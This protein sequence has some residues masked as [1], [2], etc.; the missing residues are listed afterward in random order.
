ML[1]VCAYQLKGVL[2]KLFQL[3]L[4]TCTVPKSWKLS[5]IVPVPKKPVA[6][7]LN[8]F[9]HI[10]LT[11]IL[12]KSM[13]RVVSKHITSSVSCSLDYLQFAYKSNR[14]TDDATVTLFNIIAKHLQVTNHYARVLFIDFTS[15]FNT[16]QIHIL[17][18][19]LVDL[20][21]NGG[22]IH[23]VRDFLSNRPQRVR[24]SNTVSEEIVLNTGAPQGTILSP[25]LFSIYTN[26]FKIHH[27]HFRLLKYTDDMA[28]VA[29]LKRGNVHTLIMYQPYRTGK[30]K[31]DKG[32]CLSK[33]HRCDTANNSPWTT[34]YIC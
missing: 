6:T 15:A 23:W 16:M 33:R 4:Q 3:L 25:L 5:N 1:K 30:C 8:D 26:E 11:S 21:V 10:A 24:F 34:Q 7:E 20:G 22:I 19:R 12:C 31:H 13:E 9:G 32:A 29:L 27:D 18:Q 28:L 2:T 17:L 14:S